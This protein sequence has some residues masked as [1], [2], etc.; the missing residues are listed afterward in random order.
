M[1]FFN[2]NENQNT[3]EMI[4][5]YIIVIENSNKFKVMSSFYKLQ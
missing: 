3:F 5:K 2:H 1:K 4:N